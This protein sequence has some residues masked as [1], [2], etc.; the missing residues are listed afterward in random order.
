MCT[1]SLTPLVLDLGEVFRGDLTL[2][3]ET[4]AKLDT[5]KY[6]ES[7]KIIGFLT[8]DR[9]FQFSRL[10]IVSSSAEFA[11]VRGSV[12]RKTNHVEIQKRKLT[13]LTKV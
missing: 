8:E 12:A 4:R 7:I 5:S 6:V 9:N 3:I 1:R 13:T 2:F 11:L 10:S